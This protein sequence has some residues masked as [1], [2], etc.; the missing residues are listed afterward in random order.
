MASFA[1]LVAKTLIKNNSNN[2]EE[3]NKE[4]KKLTNIKLT[5][6]KAGPKS[7]K[8]EIYFRWSDIRRKRRR[9]C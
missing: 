1:K 9:R 6:K 4:E 7:N 8:I 5:K 2:L 3:S